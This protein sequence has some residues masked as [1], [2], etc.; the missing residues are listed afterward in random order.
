MPITL[1]TLTDSLS[2]NDGDIVPFVILFLIAALGFLFFYL[3]IRAAVKSGIKKFYN[4]E[5]QTAFRDM[6]Y[7][8][9]ETHSRLLKI[10]DAQA[11][12]N[13]AIM[14]A[15]KARAYKDSFKTTSETDTQTDAQPYA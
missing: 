7:K 13:T 11:K 12:I 4:N 3:I 5:F 10:N 6:N 15:E 14:E 2:D 8:I 9:D 1:L